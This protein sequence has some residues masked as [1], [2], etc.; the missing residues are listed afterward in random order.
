MAE[1]YVH[2]VTSE[3]PYRRVGGGLYG[4]AQRTTQP[5]R[6]MVAETIHRAERPHPR[7]VNK[8]GTR[9]H[10]PETAV[11]GL[12]TSSPGASDQGGPGRM[13][14]RSGGVSE[15]QLGH[16]PVHG[17]RPRTVF[18]RLIGVQGGLS[19]PRSFLPSL[20]HPSPQLPLG[21]R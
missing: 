21:R 5:N 1:R 11:R 13:I 17:A 18:V 4:R 12:A 16:Q 8:S 19:R 20:P 9:V 2:H 7:K 3:T 14:V 10:S 15:Y 6:Q